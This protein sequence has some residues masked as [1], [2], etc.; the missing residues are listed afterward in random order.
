MK[1]LNNPALNS[2]PFPYIHAEER[3][4]M[5]LFDTVIALI[6]PFFMACFYYGIRSLALGAM[7]M[8]AA[9]LANWLSSVLNGRGIE[10]WDSSPLVTGAIIALLMPASIPFHIP[11]I[12]AVFAILVVKFPY[13]G[14]GNNLFNPAAAGLC[15]GALCFGEQ[16]AKYP[17]PLEPLSMTVDA[18]TKFVQSPAALLK[19]DAIPAISTEQ[20]ALGNYAGPMGATNIIVITA[21]L[22]YLLVRRNVKWYVPVT[23][24]ATVSL[25]AAKIHH[26]EIT[27]LE[28]V[29]LELVAGSLMF[30]AVYM[31][32]EPVTQ[33]KRA[34]AKI[35]YAVT[36]GIITMLFRYYGAVQYSAA[37]ALLLTNAFAPF[38]DWVIEQG[39]SA[40]L[41]LAEGKIKERSLHHEND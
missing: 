30:V 19:M 32:T 12:C 36:A 31:L 11:M 2:R 29:I 3:S 37:F 24:L 22:V 16:L 15:F 28:S 27:S 14:T 34:A 9:L 23:Y 8:T 21:C 13:G 6:P 38:F 33:P 20:L 5:L 39:G 35:L 26:P 41:D 10:W 18:G 17:V 40:A 25:F 4:T 7:T 1:Q